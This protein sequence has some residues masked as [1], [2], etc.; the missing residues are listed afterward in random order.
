MSDDRAPT[1]AGG[2]PVAPGSTEA[3]AM[4]SV[5]RASAQPVHDATPQAAHRALAATV[6]DEHASDIVPIATDMVNAVNGV[7]HHP[8]AAASTMEASQ[9]TATPSVSEAESQVG[10]G[11]GA[12]ETFP[13]PVHMSDDYPGEPA[14]HAVAGPSSAPLNATNAQATSPTACVFVANLAASCS[15]AQL[16][17]S[18]REI[19]QQFGTLVEVKIRRDPR[20]MPFA[21]VHYDTD[22]AAQRAILAGRNQYINGRLCRTEP[23]RANRALYL[24]RLTG[25]PVSEEEARAAFTG[26]GEIERCWVSSNTERAMYQLPE[27]IWVQFHSYEEC[28]DARSAFRRHPEY[29]VDSPPSAID[30]SPRGLMP[31]G[32]SAQTAQ[33]ARLR[34]LPTVDASSIFIGNLPENATHAEVASMVSAIG[35]VR[36]VEVVRRPGNR[37]GSHVVF[38][39]ANFIIERD[40]GRAIERLHGGIFQGRVLRVEPRTAP[41]GPSSFRPAMGSAQRNPL[42]PVPSRLMARRSMPTLRGAAP[43]TV[44]AMTASAT[45]APTTSVP[46]MPAPATMAPA[47]MAPAVM[48]PATTAPAM[49][50]PVTPAPAIV[51][52]EAR[53]SETRPSWMAPI[54]QINIKEHLKT[55]SGPQKG[56]FMAR[57]GKEM[58]DAKKA[59]LAAAAAANANGE[60]SSSSN[61]N[62][63]ATANGNA[64]V[65]SSA[66]ANGNANVTGQVNA[67]SG[68]RSQL[69]EAL[70]SVLEHNQRT[71]ANASRP[72]N[73][74]GHPV[75]AATAGTVPAPAPTLA[76]TYESAPAYQGY[77]VNGYYQAPAPQGSNGPIPT[78]A[79]MYPPYYGYATAAQMAYQG[80]YGV[81]APMNM[82]YPYYPMHYGPTA[83]QENGGTSA[84]NIPASTMPSTAYTQQQATMPGTTYPQQQPTMPGTTYPQQQ[85][86]MPGTTYPQQQPDSQ[87]NL[88]GS[89]HRGA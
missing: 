70:H 46:A 64:N 34:L 80:Y 57:Y 44:P 62:V 42:P 38:A 78:T 51:S 83:V 21:F 15:D 37:M 1:N 50:A 87:G 47:T 89:G 27:G 9:G 5:Q 54:G 24:S 29:R 60:G 58:K 25:G 36:S 67:G 85:P 4:D 14:Q 68:R 63:D 33:A 73:S 59:A 26:R 8:H 39:F 86:N 28:R 30:A 84:N 19:F 56:L 45:S 3:R 11:Q 23:A 32:T 16:E 31:H 82:N 69:S 61:A 71:N 48:A 52:S 40:A 65:T 74:G 22:E 72:M 76:T 6:E 81:P 66:N 20:G 18:V 2:P 13:I 41:S 12:T 43:I 10:N 88:P 17:A 77:A 49:T 55:L 75:P 35:P 7:T 53:P 79:G